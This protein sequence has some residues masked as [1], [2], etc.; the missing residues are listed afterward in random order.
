MDSVEDEN[1]ELTIFKDLYI[2]E[3]DQRD[4]L[5]NRVQLVFAVIIIVSTNNAYIIKNSYLDTSREILVS[6][7]LL[8]SLVSI[9]T[10]LISARYLIKA[11]WNNSYELIDR[12]SAFIEFKKGQE[13][14]KE[15]MVDYAIRISSDY[16]DYIMIPDPHLETLR[17]FKEEFARCSSTNA[18]TNASRSLNI[19]HSIQK[20][21]FA[22]GFLIFAATIFIMADLDTASPRKPIL[23]EPTCISCDMSNNGKNK[24]L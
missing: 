6:S 17:H 8:L 18:D 23:V 13:S 9:A 15:E 21:L 12:P 5:H 11:A 14:H 19:H 2:F 10:T 7:T 22:S 16:D 4:K 3:L 20:L 1:R 24:D